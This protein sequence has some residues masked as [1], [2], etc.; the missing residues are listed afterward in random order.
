[1]VLVQVAK[2]QEV[3]LDG[4]TITGPQSVYAS[5]YDGYSAGT[6][7]VG[8]SGCSLVSSYSP[9]QET[10]ISPCI[11]LFFVL[12]LFFSRFASPA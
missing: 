6:L 4:V 9:L 11:L 10:I 1:M 12:G 3:T 2:D 8:A 5:S 7:T